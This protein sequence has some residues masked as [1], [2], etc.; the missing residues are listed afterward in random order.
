MNRKDENE[1][2]AQYKIV[3]RHNRDGE[4]MFAKVKAPTK[5]E[6]EKLVLD[7]VG[8]EHYTVSRSQLA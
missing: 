6:A 2:M 4:F 1:E 8:R 5:K 7:R 3:L